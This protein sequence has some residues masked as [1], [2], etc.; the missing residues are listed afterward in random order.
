MVLEAAI[1]DLGGTLVYHVRDTDEL[2]RL[3]HQAMTSYL[4]SKGLNVK[5]DDIVKV[6]NRIYNSYSS[7]AKESFIELDARILYSAILYQL[8]V[9]EYSNEDLITGAINSFY[10][11]ILDDYRIFEDAKEVL[12]EI[13]GIGLKLGLVTNNHSTDF[14][15]RLLQKFNLDK[16]F[17]AIVVSS[18]IGIRK[19]HKGIF[20]H[21]LK[22]LG[23]NNESSI[24]IGDN[25][26]QDIQ[27]AKNAGIRSIWIKRKRYDEVPTK[28]DWTVESIRQAEEIIFSE[29]SNP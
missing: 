20:L 19:P 18:E 10:S 22:M 13:K 1:F 11:P 14:H 4:I 16:F 6:S 29:C 21:C 17:D 5:P 15:L 25:P 2:I 28:P 7:F 3:S 12:R 24:F 8:G 26:T 23:V 9:A 27:G